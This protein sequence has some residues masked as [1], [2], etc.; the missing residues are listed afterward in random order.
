MARREIERVFGAPRTE[1]L[2]RRIETQ[3]RIAQFVVESGVGEDDGVRADFRWMHLPTPR[4][5]GAADF[6]DVGKIGVEGN[7]EAQRTA[8]LVVVLDGN[9]LISGAIPQEANTANVDCVVV[10]RDAAVGV[11]HVGI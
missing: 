6:E 2:W 7:A 5:R 3:M 9:A 8:L 4:A 1:V 11:V 10:K